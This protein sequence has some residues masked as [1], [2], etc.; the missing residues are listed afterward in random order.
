MMTNPP[1]RDDRGSLEAFCALSVPNATNFC[2]SEIQ[3]PRRDRPYEYE[4]IGPVVYHLEAGSG[5]INAVITS[6]R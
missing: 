6:W 1:Q 4:S 3:R 2:P 5:L